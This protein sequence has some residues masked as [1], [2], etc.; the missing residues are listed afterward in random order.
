LGIFLALC[1]ILWSFDTLKKHFGMLYQE[2]SGNP[3]AL[4]RPWSA[5]KVLSIIN[6]YEKDGDKK[7]VK[8]FSQKFVSFEICPQERGLFDF[9][10]CPDNDVIISFGH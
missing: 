7:T 5:L 10:E 8:F 4:W 2:Q 9:S 1:Y 3:A 6:R